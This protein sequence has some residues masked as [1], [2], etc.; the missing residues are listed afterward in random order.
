MSSK[1]TITR[2]IDNTFVFTIKGD[3]TTLPMDIAGWTFTGYL[4]LLSSSFTSPAIT[5]ELDNDSNTSS[6]RTTLKLTA[7]KVANL[8][9]LKGS[10]VDRY[11]VKP[12][13]K[14]VIRGVKPNENDIV[15]KV[16]EVYVD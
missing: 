1:F 10:E 8:V 15:A 12:S 6:G 11:Y 4:Y 16:D 14:L 2:G 13:Y 3:N 9:S 5:E 7:D